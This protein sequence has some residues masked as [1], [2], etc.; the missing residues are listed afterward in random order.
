M[1]KPQPRSDLVAQAGELSPEVAEVLGSPPLIKGEDPEE[2]RRLLAA[3]GAG[4]GAADIAD[5]LL[6]D[7]A[8]I[9][10][11]ALRRMRDGKEWL[12]EEG[13]KQRTEEATRGALEDAVLEAAEKL[14]QQAEASSAR[15]LKSHL[16]AYFEGDDPAKLKL[17]KIK[18]LAQWL[19][20][21]PDNY[22]GRHELALAETLSESATELQPLEGLIETYTGR[23]QR[24]LRE[25]DR[26]H[27]DAAKLQLVA[28]EV[29]R[30][31]LPGQ[32]GPYSLEGRGGR[33]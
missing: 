7:Q 22:V 2:Y 27:L 15:I 10:Y 18:E 32:V 28:D 16:D 24:I 1:A 11:W 31:A 3:L 6:V 8:A 30:R 14:R 26:R 33:A 9:T 23:L 5:W 12:L 20:L 19:G 4:A 13:T 21:E 29:L 25:I 17:S